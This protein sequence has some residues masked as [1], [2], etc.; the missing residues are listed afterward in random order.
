LN[1]TINYTRTV[2]KASLIGGI[3]LLTL[4]SCG[5]GSK[6]TVPILEMQLQ[7]MDGSFTPGQARETM[8]IL[9]KRLIGSGSKTAIASLDKEG[10]TITLQCDSVQPV[11][12]SQQLIKP[13]K[14]DF[15]E[16][17]SIIDLAPFLKVASFEIDKPGT[18]KNAGINFDGLKKEQISE[19]F[20][21][22]LMNPEEPANDAGTG[23]MLTMPYLGHVRESD[24]AIFN[25]LIPIAQNYLPVDCKLI[26][27][28][29]ETAETIPDG[30]FRLYAVKDNDSRM[31][32]NKYLEKVEAA[33][34]GRDRPAIRL[35]FNVPGTK[36]WEMMTKRCINKCIAIVIDEQVL[37]APRVISAISGGMSEISGMFTESG[38]KGIAEMM[39][40]GYLPLRLVLVA[41][42]QVPG[43]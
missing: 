24:T 13:M 28:E 7:I 38:T 43:K 34:D 5:Q 35:Q 23:A 12:I 6:K 9:K 30:F 4:F 27:G 17:Y 41:I 14:L 2:K 3:S 1:S 31:E 19:N 26:Y 20:F 16:C 33:M 21:L 25:K 32:G 18:Q 22:A 15:Y 37:S 36:N 40:A 8:E 10:N 42:R 11:F 29:R 39:S